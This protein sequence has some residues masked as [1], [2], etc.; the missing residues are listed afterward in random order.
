[1]RGDVAADGDRG[2]DLAFWVIDRAALIRSLIEA[3]SP[4]R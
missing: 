4:T 1:L 3:P 2:H